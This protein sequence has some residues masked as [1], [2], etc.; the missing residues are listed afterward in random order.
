M[1]LHLLTTLMKWAL[2]LSLLG[3]LVFGLYLAHVKIKAERDSEEGEARRRAP[4]QGPRSFVSLEEDEAERYGLKT[5]KARSVRWY[6]RVPAYGRVVPNP[7]AT[8]EVRSP[9][10]G[11]LRSAPDISWPALGQQ[12]RKGQTLGWVDVRVGPEVRLDLQT[13]LADA[14]IRQQGAEEEIK[15]QQSRVDSLKGVTSQQILSRAELDAALIQLARARNQLATAKAAAALWQKALQ[16]VERRKGDTASPWCQPLVAP[17]DG[18]ITTLAGRSG[19]SIEAGARV[20]ELVDF[21]R[22]LIRLD[23]PPEILTHGGPPLKLEVQVPAASLPSLNGTLGPSPSTRSFPSAQFHLAGPAPRVD[24]ASQF[25]SYWY[26]DPS[27]PGKDAAKGGAG[28][29]AVL[30]RPGMQVQAEVRA[31]GT[32]PEEA[33]AVPAGAVL[34]HEGRPLVYVRIAPEKFQRREVRLLG[35]EGS[36]WVLAAR[37]GDL[38]VGVKAGEAVVSRQAQVLLSKEFLRADEDD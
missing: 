18:E 15:L 13:K 28:A 4:A 11:T 31:A 27:P 26:D 8:T 17:T 34:Y 36:N 37:Q 16:A 6:P 14:R 2:S 1:R 33:L 25:V 30:W 24:V 29:S 22:P 21:R 35:R 3:G 32:A 10:A 12:V 23:I 7:Q 19:M 20:F 9:F 5:E 38:P